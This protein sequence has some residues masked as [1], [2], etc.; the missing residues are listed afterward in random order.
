VGWQWVYIA[1]GIPAVVLGVIVF[2]ALTDKPAQAR[3]LTDEERSA[4]EAQLAL[5]KSIRS[6]HNR[7]SLGAALRH[8]KVLLLCL[9][10]FLIVTGSYGSEFFLPSILQRWYAL[11]LSAL[12]WLVM[13]PPTVSLVGQLFVGWNSDRT[14]ERRLHAAV[15]MACAGLALLVVSLTQHHL[16][17]TLLCFMVA[18]GGLKAYLPAFWSLPNLFLT[19]AA[20][21][22][23]IGLINSVGNLG[24]FL[25]PSVMGQ[26]ETWTGSFS[27]GLVF[28]GVA[29]SMAASIILALGLGKRPGVQV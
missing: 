20:A 7:M 24:G 12:T 11:D 15:P 16:T 5:E 8:P 26:V 2:F 23:S 13:L 22:G 25:G 6:A 27:G 28:L 4:L 3:W 9:A 18:A 19:E 29:A 17:L 1:W 10:Y 14:G 21:A